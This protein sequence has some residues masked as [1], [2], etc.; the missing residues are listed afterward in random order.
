MGCLGDWDWINGPAFMGYYV[1]PERHKLENEAS[2]LCLN[3]VLHVLVSRNFSAW[4]DADR[5]LTSVIGQRAFDNSRLGICTSSLEAS[6]KETIFYQDQ[7]QTQQKNISEQQGTI[8]TCVVSLAKINVPEPLRIRSRGVY[9]FG[10]TG[11]FLFQ[12]NRRIPA[13]VGRLKCA[14][15]F[16]AVNV[17]MFS[18]ARQLGERLPFKELHKDLNLDF[19]G[20][21]WEPEDPIVAILNTTGQ[22]FEPDSCVLSQP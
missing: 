21:A 7:A 3:T 8:N 1:C 19:N 4:H 16:N 11:V 18:G 6:E 17:S 22:N 5:N 14:Q 2:P 13:F 20:V 12:T 15:P 9:T 10:M